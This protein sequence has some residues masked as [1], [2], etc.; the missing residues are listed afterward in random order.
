MQ[1]RFYPPRYW[2]ESIPGKTSGTACK[3][4]GAYRLTLDTVVLDTLRIAKAVR[5]HLSEAN[6]KHSIQEIVKEALGPITSTSPIL[7]TDAV[8]DNHPMEEIDYLL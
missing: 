1:A 6:C 3:I 4:N 7:R 5:V 8:I 2:K